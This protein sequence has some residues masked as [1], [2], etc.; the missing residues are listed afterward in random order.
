[1][2]TYLET[3]KRVG[4]VLMLVGFVDLA[5]MVYCISTEKS[6]SSSLNIFAVVAGVFLWRGHLGA[7]RLVARFSA[8]FLATAIGTLLFLVPFLQPLDLWVTRLK[9]NPIASVL[10]F[11]VTLALLGLLA[12]TYGQLRA[13]PVLQALQN[14]GRSITPPR[15]AMGIGIVLPL[16]LTA[17]FHFTLSGEAG[18]KAV[19]LA[20]AEYGDQYKYAPTAINW[21]GNHVSAKL[22]AYNDYEI[23]DVTVEW[24]Q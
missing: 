6:Y 5:Y 2:R 22:T 10:G 3:L 18:V 1:V 19:D 14:D 16:V 8:F 20:R 24:Q 13:A 21:A 23:K 4:V 9:L 7:V 17:L 12:W 15:L 11:M